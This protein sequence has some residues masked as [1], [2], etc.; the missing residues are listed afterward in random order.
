[1]GGFKN[2]RSSKPNQTGRNDKPSRF[3]ML[4]H[5]LLESPAYAMLDPVGRCLLV[6]LISLFDGKNNGRIYLSTKDA[7]ARLGRSDER[8]VIA[9]FHLL[10]AV[11]LIEQTKGAHFAI[12][13]GETSRARCW[14][15]SWLVWPECPNRSKR[16]PS[17][18][19]LQY[20][21]SGKAADRRLRALAKYRKAKASGK[22]SA[23]ESTVQGQYSCLNAAEPAAEIRAAKS[24]I[25]ANLPKLITVNFTAYLDDTRGSIWGWWANKAQTALVAQWL[26]VECFPRPNLA[27]AV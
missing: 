6:E 26:Y 8:A 1:M 25:D 23:V 17:L 21:A 5:R 19:Y 2:K 22:F 20:Q 10:Q 13:T 11:G 27:L 18:D 14:R 4:D 24:E 7:T 3:V 15:L 16:F 9:A 12:K